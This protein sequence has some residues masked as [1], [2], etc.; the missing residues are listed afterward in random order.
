MIIW[1]VGCVDWRNP[2]VSEK[3]IASILRAE[4]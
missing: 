1:V 2:D 3:Y 4:E